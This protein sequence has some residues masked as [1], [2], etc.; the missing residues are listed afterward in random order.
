MVGAC[1]QGTGGIGFALF[2]APIVALVHPELLPGPMI[3]LGGSVS[4]L[5]AV[6]E[7]RSIDYADVA[8]ALVGRVPGAIVAGLVIGLLPRAGFSILFA[9][10]ILAAVLLSVTGWRVQA[11]RSTLAAAG[12]ASGFMGT[13]T[14]VGT[15][16]M[17]LVMQN[18][19]PAR[20]RATVG[21]FLVFGSIVSLV[22]LAWAGRFD[23]AG[24]RLSLLLV[25]PM[26][27]GFWASTPL[28]LRVNAALMRRVVLGISV[29]SA[30]L[31]IAQHV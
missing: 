31:L 13:I 28:V 27:L 5:A 20:L 2:A 11:T 25:V 3:V 8:A 12:F 21:L 4:L 22:V 29:L 14:S 18:V 17:G 1:I 16:P 7:F 9:L 10:L 6:R 26:V 23:W 19:E 24:L 30:L 15:P